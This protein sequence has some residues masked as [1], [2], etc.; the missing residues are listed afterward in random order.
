[1]FGNAV[2]KSARARILALWQYATDANAGLSSAAMTVHER[3]EEIYAVERENIYSYLLGFRVPAGRAQELT[4]DS[5]LKLYLKM[6]RG[7]Q[8]DN[9]RAWLYRVAHNFA[10]RFHEREPAFDELDPNLSAC[11]TALDPEHALIELERRSALLTAIRDLS[12]QQRNCL[13]LRVQGLRYREIADVIGISTS[14]V[15]E[16]LRRAVTRLKGAMDGH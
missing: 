8:I 12:P 14:A 3:V 5:F 9:P 4:Q 7:E 11:E 16:F 2:D 13:H 15:G 10:L 6:S 1:M